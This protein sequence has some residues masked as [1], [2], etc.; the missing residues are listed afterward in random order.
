MR[1]LVQSEKQIPVSY[2]LSFS[3]TMPNT[4][5]TPR[6]K[7]TETCPFCY[8]LI[9]DRWQDHVILCSGQRFQCLTCGA[10]FKKNAYLAKHM[11][12]HESGSVDKELPAKTKFQVTDEASAQDK[13][14]SDRA[15]S[16]VSSSAVVPVTSDND[17]QDVEYDSDWRDQDP[18]EVIDG[19]IGDCS[20]SED[21]AEKMDNGTT[22]STDK[23]DDLL[24]GR[25]IRKKTS[26]CIY[27]GVKR[28][29]PI[30]VS[31][32]TSTMEIVK[33][34]TGTQTDPITYVQSS[35]KITT[36]WENGIKVRLIEKRKFLD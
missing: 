19:C 27:S 23:N 33:L 8:K 13:A 31:T 36:K 25:L 28:V 30:S 7:E 21:E 1:T 5:K 9:L 24:E 17:L 12:K 20:S 4:T 15:E 2:I 34:E 11:K 16:S 10:R 6:N 22:Q 3:E 32:Q 26:S 35:K 18:G 14:V 29:A